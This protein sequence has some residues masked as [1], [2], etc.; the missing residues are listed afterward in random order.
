[1]AL[2]SMLDRSSPPASLPDVQSQPDFVGQAIEKVGVTDVRYPLVFR[3][4]N[5]VQ[6]T[7]ATWSMM[8]SLQKNKRGT[9]MSR[10]VQ[11]LAN[12]SGHELTVDSTIT[13]CESIQDRLGSEQAF[14]SIEFPWFVEKTAPVSGE[15]SKLDVQ[16]QLDVT[17][18]ASRDCLLTLKVPATSLCPCSKEISQYGA[19]NQ[20]CEL[21]VALRFSEGQSISIEEL[22]QI[23]E[24]SAS[25]SLFTVIKRDDEKQLTE[26]AYENPRFVEDTVRHLADSL[27]QEPRISWYRCASEN[28]ESIHNHNAFAQIECDKNATV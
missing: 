28:F 16:V 24:S 5:D 7:I 2:C 18:G 11:I 4:S 10:F 3:S 15:K 20:R 21:T 17:T 8:V 27:Q 12:M 9:H 1:M 22:V 14:V 19:H 26:Q 6:S 23:A 13:L 25:A